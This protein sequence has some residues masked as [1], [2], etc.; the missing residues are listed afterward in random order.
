[1]AIEALHASAGPELMTSVD[2]IFGPPRPGG[3]APPKE[4]RDARASPPNEPKDRARNDSAGADD[5][6]TDLDI[7]DLFEAVVSRWRLLFVSL[8]LTLSLAG[9]YV[10]VTPAR[11]AATMSFLVDPRDHVTSGVDSTT[12]GQGPDSPLV[13]NQMR[14]LTSNTV[15]RRVVEDLHLQS[16]PEF[17]AVRPSGLFVALKSL[18]FGAP[19]LIEP[20]V[21][22][23]SEILTRSISVKRSDK[24]YVIDV[25]TRAA[26]PEKAERIAHALASAFL[27]IQAQFSA[28]VAE[29]EGQWLDVKIEDLRKRL[30]QAEQRVQD[31]RQA[32]SVIVTEGLTPSEQQ[33]KTANAALVE[34]RGKRA[35][36]EA[37][38]AQA[39]AA[40][41]SGAIET[42]KETIR[43]PLLERLLADYSSLSRESANMQATLG[44]R[45]PAF[46]ANQSQLAAQ[47]AQ[48]NREMRNVVETQRRNVTSAR[49]VER[50]AEGQ[51]AELSKSIN[52]NGGKQIELG[53]LERQSVVLRD[54][55]GKALAARENTHAEVISSPNPVLINQPIA[56]SARVSPKTLPAL[57][58]AFAAGI[59]LWIAAALSLE[60]IARRQAAKGAA[61][62]AA[63]GAV[64]PTREQE[65]SVE[66]APA[67]AE[68]P[69]G[70]DDDP[71]GEASLLI[72][73]P[74][75]DPDAAAK[76]EGD[77]QENDGEDDDRQDDDR[78]DD[79]R[80][81]EG[82]TLARATRAMDSRH[83][84]YRR[85]IVRLYDCMPGES[86]IHGA[87][88]FFAV[89]ARKEQSGGSTLALALAMIACDRGDRVLVIDCNGRHPTLAALL[90]FLTPVGQ[91]QGQ[92]LKIFAC[93]RDERS[94]GRL[95]LAAFKPGDL[96]PDRRLLE[97]RFDL[98]LL[99]CGAHETLP[100]AFD[101]TL[102]GMIT[103]DRDQTNGQRRA[104]LTLRTGAPP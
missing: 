64:A 55:Y 8:A 82:A 45:H 81:D 10:L 13:E 77:R 63:T 18:F 60:F 7:G 76:E 19:A 83:S 2:L 26:S 40:I 85:A 98:V 17:G 72:P 56:P 57:I 59:N 80:E 12:T 73:L 48:I 87:P 94:G 25:E 1:M 47:R 52:A 67:G 104:R 4:P 34:A 38:Y 89:T 88:P 43:S 65:A 78:K 93:R 101:A 74:C 36:A 3:A 46:I 20:S 96:L 97:K 50:A 11:Y 68:S 5:T 79:D 100:P 66:Q 39:Q 29:K 54:N 103:V 51:V 28:S 86:A 33:I 90:P 84:P 41:Q 32:Q 71:P 44:P 30:E 99:D 31:Y 6:R 24:S 95:M 69:Q 9:L 58:I 14:L 92:A 70:Q 23:V 102:T 62:V 27:A 42:A 22:Q 53:A 75:I 35:E 61:T 21:E 15:L 49:N 37:K 16:D 91:N